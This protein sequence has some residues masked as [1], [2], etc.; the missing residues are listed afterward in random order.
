MTIR[1]I[2]AVEA[3]SEPKPAEMLA[4]RAKQASGAELS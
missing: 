4:L 2:L 3:F 1:E